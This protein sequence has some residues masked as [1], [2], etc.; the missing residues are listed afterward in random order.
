MDDKKC[1]YWERVFQTI[2][3]DKYPIYTKLEYGV[4]PEDEKHEYKTFDELW[5]N[6]CNFRCYGYT[7]K[8]LF[9]KEE[10]RLLWYRSMETDK[11]LKE[12]KFKSAILEIKYDEYTLNYS[13]KEL[14]EKLTADMFFDYCRDKLSKKYIPTKGDGE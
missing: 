6:R 2:N 9:R 1:L 11:R 8:R 14:S 3:G 12:T 4:M 13:I 7:R 10:E 5:Q